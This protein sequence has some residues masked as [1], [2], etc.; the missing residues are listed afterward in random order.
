MTKSCTTLSLRTPLSR[1]SSSSSWPRP[2][3]ALARALP[4]I[5][6]ARWC[7]DMPFSLGYC[8]DMLYLL[9]LLYVRYDMLYLKRAL[10]L[11]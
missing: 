10:V 1:S 6:L 11:A 8:Y 2:M 7:Y 4:A 3:Y 5:S 9:Y